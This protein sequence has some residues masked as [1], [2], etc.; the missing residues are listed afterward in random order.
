MTETGNLTVTIQGPRAD[1]TL[2]RPEVRN[3]FDDILVGALAD[4]ARKLAADPAVRVV[5]LRGAGKAFCAG[6]D[7]NWMQR[8]VRYTEKENLHDASVMAA[9]FQAWSDIPKPVIGRIHGAA[10]GGGTGLVAVCDIAVA[11]TET[12]FA[13]SEVRLGILPA[14]ISP[15]VLARIGGSAARDLFLTG[16]RFTAQ[17]ALAIGLVHRLTSPAE[18]DAKVDTVVQSVLAGGPEAQT[19]IKTLIPQVLAGTPAETRALTA[20]TIA[21]A[22]ASAE[23]QEG[24]RAFLDRRRAAWREDA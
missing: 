24:L 2:H 20:R 16:D 17:R 1:V 3:A 6:A 10:I 12:V 22:R 11:E 7:V 18:L 4:A 13:F 8:M 5:V 23:G 15:F 19:R 21:H 9:M 14:V